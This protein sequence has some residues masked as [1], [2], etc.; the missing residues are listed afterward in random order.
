MK[1]PNAPLSARFVRGTLRASNYNPEKTRLSLSLVEG[2]SGR[3]VQ[4][5]GSD[6]S[7]RF[8]FASVDPG[9]YFLRLNPSGLKGLSGEEITGLITIEVSHDSEVSGLDLDLGWSSCGLS[10]VNQSTCRQPKLEVSRV[11]GDVFDV[12]GALIS[13]AEILLL[14]DSEM[15]RILE[16]THTDVA[17][18]FSLVEPKDGIYQL[19]VESPGFSPLRRTLHVRPAEGSGCQRPIKVQ[20]S[21]AGSCSSS[22]LPESN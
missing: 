21:I 1:W 5:S 7:G 2:L 12:S 9:I 20:M 11:C 18:Q 19:A 8:N 4:T 15:A 22:R 17:G 3:V 13:N 6:S 14:E 10:Y 16:R